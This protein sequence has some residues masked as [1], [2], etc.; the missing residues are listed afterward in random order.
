MRSLLMLS[1]V[2]LLATTVAAQK[3]VKYSSQNY[4]GLLEGAEKSR[5]QLQTIH[6]IKFANTWYTGLGTGLDYYYFRSVPLF[7][8]VTKNFCACER[9]FY[10]TINGGLNWVWDNT[11]A[12]WVNDWRDGDFTTRL[13]YEASM[14]YRIGLRNN[15]D[16]L[17]LNIGY[18]VKQAKE[19]IN[20]VIGWCD[21]F[22]CPTGSDELKYNF[23]RLSLK[24]GWEF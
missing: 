15:K 20:T 5:F 6:G 16:A 14:G 8:S 4:I 24:V 18:S 10:A 22:P 3:K 23:R 21:V 2:L 17:L 11:T 1:L 19:K 13:F 7:L 12:H 9:S